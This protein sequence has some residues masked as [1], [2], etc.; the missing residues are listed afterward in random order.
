MTKTILKGGAIFVLC[1]TLA[2]TILTL[3]QDRPTD[4]LIQEILAVEL[5]RNPGDSASEEAKE[6]YKSKQR[7]AMD[8]RSELIGELYKVDPNMPELTIL[9]PQRWATVRNK[10]SLAPIFQDELKDVLARTQDASLIQEAR[11]Y[12]TIFRMKEAGT[13]AKPESLL[14]I[15]EPF[16]QKYPKDLR[17]PEL[18][19][20]LAEGYEDAGARVVLYA[21]VEKTYPGS[22]LLEKIFVAKTIAE[23][24]NR[25]LQLIGKP[26]ELE[27]TDAIKGTKVSMADLKGKVVVVDFWATWCVPCVQE[28]PNMKKLYAQYK[29][30]GVEFIGVSLDKPVEEGGFDQLKEFVAKNEIPWP[31]YYPGQGFESSFASKW[32]VLA[33]PKI[34]VVDAEGNL[35]STKGQGQLE[36][37]IP[38][39]V[40]KAKKPKS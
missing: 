37:L 17:I 9:L 8:R 10:P 18:L 4:R 15:V 25:L 23:S 38:E 11:F 21:W 16:T 26:F 36:Q 22:P 30:Q 3:L 14:E 1:G 31:Q 33:I 6:K 20:S 35:A 24:E 2:L 19:I 27:F 29:D 12:Q 7:K 40:A 13:N 5:P 32:E 39:Y 34:Y 28:T